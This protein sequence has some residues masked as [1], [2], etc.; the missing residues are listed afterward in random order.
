VKRDPDFEN[1]ADM[2]LVDYTR[3]S[4]GLPSPDRPRWDSRISADGSGLPEP[5]QPERR[6][7]IITAE[8]ACFPPGPVIPGAV[9]T[10]TLGLVNDGSEAAAGLTVGVPVPGG[11]TYREGS[12]ERDGRPVDPSGVE[13]FLRGAYCVDEL[14]PGSRAVL[15]WQL[16]VRASTGPIV[17]APVIRADTGAVLGGR[18]FVVERAQ[19]RP[20]PTAFA[21][22][23][24]QAVMSMTLPATGMQ[25]RPFY[26]LDEAEELLHEAV[27]AAPAS[28][29]PS[30]D[31]PAAAADAPPA[32]EAVLIANETAPV[33][34]SSAST[35]PP[36][37]AQP[38]SSPSTESE[39]ESVRR[40][41][42]LLRELD[43]ATIAYFER[44][45]GGS[46]PATILDHALFANALATWQPYPGDDDRLGLRRF[47]DE[48][49][50]ILQRLSLLGRLGKRDPIAAHAGTPP[51]E[52]AALQ[53]WEI[54]TIEDRPRGRD[55]LLLAS[56][57]GEAE[58]EA[59]RRLIAEP[60]RW[61]FAKA[62]QL[63]ALFQ[64]RAVATALAAD[65]ASELTAA[66]HAYA[67]A[68]STAFQRLF[69]RLRLDR[70]TGPL[71][72]NDA[73]ADLAA[74][75]LL[76]LLRRAVS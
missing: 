19:R 44:T 31:V 55:R 34:R 28:G 33:E 3:T 75:R 25:E 26:E 76:A 60:A 24:E 56:E 52:L 20:L 30:I 45:L 53:P 42:L 58:A 63:T 35:E 36:L 74:R 8:L 14:A 70:T 51:S 65:L 62:R 9:L 61:E 10:I 21:A 40:A 50:R 5:G 16:D 57:L 72:Q 17:V 71:L 67:H 2:R 12:L 68:S 47:L 37:A 69:V 73:E 23:V 64:P 43:P 1:S 49:G 6:G 66:L 54:G 27:D 11:A 46:K 7:A 48:Q 38:P 13:A 4:L 18:P 59:V 22:A 32:G 15:K 29:V 41:V 39:R